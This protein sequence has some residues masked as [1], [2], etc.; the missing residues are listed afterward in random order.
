MGLS[1]AQGFVRAMAHDWREMV[2]GPLPPQIQKIVDHWQA[3]GWES[4]RCNLLRCRR[5][6]PH[7][8]LRAT[9]GN[10]HLIIGGGV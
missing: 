4:E 2:E 9:A 8:H 7:A 10:G 1:F 3:S 6:Y 5:L